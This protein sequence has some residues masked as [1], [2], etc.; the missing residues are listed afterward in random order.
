MI[1]RALIPLALVTLAAC[2]DTDKEAPNTDPVDLDADGYADDVDC[3][4]ADAEVRPGAAELCDGVDQ[5]CDGQVDE[6][7]SDAST[8]YRDRDDDGYGDAMDP[9]AACELPAGYTSRDGDCDDG[10]ATFHP[11]AAE[12]DC[13][14]PADYNCDGSVGY[15][16]EDGDGFAACE[17]CDDTLL[18]VH[19]GAV[20]VCDGVDNDCDGDVDTGAVDARPWYADGDGDGY[21]AAA[22]VVLACEAP[23]GAVADA[24]DCDDSAAGVHPGAA[25]LCD[26]VD[27]DCDGD[28]DDE[29]TDASTWY[30]DLDGDGAAGTRV[31]ARACAAPDGYLAQATDC[32]DLDASAFPGGGEVCD[33]ADNDCDGAIDEEV[34]DAPLWFT[35]ADGDGHGAGRG[36]GACEAPQ[37]MV[38]VGDDC[39]DSDASA[40]PG[41]LER[42]DGVDNNCDT[43]VDVGA[44]D[45]TTWHADMDRDGQGSPFYTVEACAQP[46]GYVASATDCDDLDPDT[47]LGA[48]ERCDGVDQSCD[49]AADDGLYG[50]LDTCPAESCLDLHRAFGGLGDGRYWIDPAGEG[51]GWEVPCDMAGGGWTGVEY[52]EDLP[53]INRWTTGDAWRWLPED[54]V[55]VL[56]LEQI[57]ALQGLSSEGHQTWVQRCEHV[58]SHYYVAGDDYNHAV[59]FRFAEGTVTGRGLAD[60]SPFD[61]EV[62]EDGCSVNGGGD[63]STE[64]DPTVFEISSPLVPV[65]NIQ[66]T[67]SGN[68]GEY[69]G[70]PLTA[71]PAWLR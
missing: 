59:S 43:R 47:Y 30:A 64:D 34:P 35:D 38:A 65:V 17:E 3:D 18:A 39:D 5:D 8:W 60:Y 11:G 32:D 12:E 66:T 29:A 36:Q 63:A 56:P 27:Q 45:A 37:G 6:D 14:D 44:V 33:G 31:V 53:Y 40:W 50:L 67:D 70:S 46:A 7:A 52:A 19:P 4:D 54:L 68:P 23:A 55:T 48:L 16:D 15:A 62:V 49:G 51:L 28:V 41:A 57:V 24:R 69:F 71:N 21:G 20:E 42:C 22:S 61:I 13:A 25:E 58:I 9:L 10:D 2:G 26:G 1:F